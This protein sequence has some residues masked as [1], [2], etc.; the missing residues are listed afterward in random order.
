MKKMIIIIGV[1]IGVS[2]L[3]DE[4]RVLASKLHL[5]PEFK[6]QKEW[7]SIMN[8]P[9]EMKKFGIDKLSVDDKDRLKKY[10]MENA[11]DLVQGANR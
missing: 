5:H 2:C 7:E 10:L 8:T 9:E 1:L 3:A 11:G 6:S 4:G